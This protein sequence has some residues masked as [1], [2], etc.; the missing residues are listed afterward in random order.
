MKRPLTVILI[1]DDLELSELLLGQIRRCDPLL[2]V[3]AFPDLASAFA[4]LERGGIKVALLDLG[5]PDTKGAEGVRR[6][7]QRFPDLTIVVIT[8]M[9]DD[10]AEAALREGAD[11]YLTK[12][13][14]SGTWL[15]KRI[16]YATIR[17]EHMTLKETL[18]D[19]KR[20]TQESLDLLGEMSV[21][22]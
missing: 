4:R 21:C 20:L 3:E 18:E 17:H 10:M 22:E 2:S 15:T 6:L 16:R 5:L 9:G 7:R 14:E 11:D 12:P 19:A 1:E 13:F 8:G